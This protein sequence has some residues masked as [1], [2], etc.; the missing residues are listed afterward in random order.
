MNGL[1]LTNYQMRYLRLVAGGIGI[2]LLLFLLTAN[3]VNTCIIDGVTVDEKSYTIHQGY[4]LFKDNAEY[5][6]FVKTYPRDPGVA[7]TF[8]TVQK[9]ENLWTIAR[10]YGITIDTILAANLFLS[11][12]QVKEKQVLVIPR[13]NGVLLAFDDYWDVGAMEERLDFPVNIKGDYRPR[14]LKLISNDDMRL[15]FFENAEPAMVHPKLET[16]YAYHRIFKK[17]V[18]GN[19]TSMFGD[20]VDPIYHSTAFHSGIDI[21]ARMGT[22]IKAAREGIVI[23]T[24]WRDG[25]G[26]TIIIQHRNGYSTIYAHLSRIKSKKGDWVTRKDTIG[27]I[28]STGR[29]TGPHLHFMLMHHGRILNPLKVI[30]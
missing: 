3:I 20:R 15:V 5:I 25:F 24:G 7:L 19:Y 27:A 11:S 9:N 8:H 13:K 30:W 6:R 26:K 4:P 14:L 28:G 21:Q 18:K 10:R 17:P 16:L 29:S 1:P 12:L 23:Y 22:P 2:F